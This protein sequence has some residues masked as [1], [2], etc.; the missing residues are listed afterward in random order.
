MLVVLSAIV[1]I[2]IYNRGLKGVAVRQKC[3][4]KFASKNLVV[5]SLSV[6]YGWLCEDVSAGDVSTAP[7]ELSLSRCDS[8]NMTRFFPTLMFGLVLVHYMLW[9]SPYINK[10]LP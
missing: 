8:Q 3:K 1:N 9:R 5:L 4:R 2:K 6:C 7:M 10:K